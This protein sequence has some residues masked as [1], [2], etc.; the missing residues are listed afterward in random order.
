MQKIKTFICSILKLRFNKNF[1]IIIGYQIAEGENMAIDIKYQN[2]VDIIL[3]H[4]H[5]LGADYWT[6]PDKR[7]VKGS[8]YSAYDSTLMLMELGMEPIDPILK[9]VAELFF[10]VWR[11]D[12]RFKLY[13]S[14]GILP[15]HTARAVS[16]LCRMGYVADERIQTTLKYFLDTPYTDGGWRCNKFSFGRGAET[17]Y[18]NPLPTLNVLDAFRFS[19][20]LNSEPALDKAV[21]F[22]LQHWIIRKPIGPCQYGMGTRFMQIEYPMGNYNLFQYVY[23]LSFY[24]KAKKDERFLE[25]LSTLQSKL[26]DGMIIVERNVPKLSKLS[27]CKK[28]KPSELAT[29]RYHEIIDNLKL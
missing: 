27:F 26:V 1:G 13:P 20:Y 17:E 29:K 15:C 3:S 28:G 10:S 9:E 5:D 18:S 21:E 8:P 2:D 24:D 25:A 6:T 19:D 14:G 22:L 4:R 11:K 7:L 23:V 12:G 16:L